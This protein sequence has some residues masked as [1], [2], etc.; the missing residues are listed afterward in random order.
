[1]RCRAEGKP[2]SEPRSV[3]IVAVNVAAEKDGSIFSPNVI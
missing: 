3:T 1:M 2:K